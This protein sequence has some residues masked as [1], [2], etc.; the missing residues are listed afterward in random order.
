MWSI[1]IHGVII[2]GL[3][4]KH[5]VQSEIHKAN[6]FLTFV[7]DHGNLRL[8]AEIVT[9]ANIKNSV[10]IEFNETTKKVELTPID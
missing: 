4:K 5:D 7:D 8:P 2:T 10:S 6:E 9:K 3:Y 1:G